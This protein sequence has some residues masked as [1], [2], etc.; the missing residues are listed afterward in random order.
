MVRNNYFNSK[1]IRMSYFIIIGNTAVYCNYK[2]SVLGCKIINCLQVK[3]V[4][5]I[6]LR[7]TP[8][9]IQ[10][11]ADKLFIKNCSTAYS[12]YIAVTKN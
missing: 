10:P 2:S 8:L 4:A 3:S 5:V 7:K 11:H 12:I 1:I 6:F 9:N